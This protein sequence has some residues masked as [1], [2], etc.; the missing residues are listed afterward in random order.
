MIKSSTVSIHI[1]LIKSFVCLHTVI[2]HKTE[3][4]FYTFKYLHL[5]SE[6]LYNGNLTV[7]TVHQLCFCMRIRCIQML[8]EWGLRRVLLHHVIFFCISQTKQWGYSNVLFSHQLK[9]NENDRHCFILREKKA[10]NLCLA[11]SLWWQPCVY[12]F[13]ELKFRNILMHLEF[14]VLNFIR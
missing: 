10:E 11:A 4:T 5:I 12:L 13:L 1:F 8:S 3:C 2:A 9:F 6:C 14:S 7:N